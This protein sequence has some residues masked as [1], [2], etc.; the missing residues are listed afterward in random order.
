MTYYRRH[1]QT[2]ALRYA[3]VDVSSDYSVDRMAYHIYMAS[4]QYVCVDEPSYD[5]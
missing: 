4:P 1:S 5:S 3:R 2:A